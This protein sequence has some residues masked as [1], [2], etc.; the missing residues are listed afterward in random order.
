MLLARASLLL[1]FIS[2][3][4]LLSVAAVKHQDFKTCS[5]SGFCRRGRAIAE[6]A[7]ASNNWKSPYSVDSSSIDISNDQSSF[8]ATV[9]SSLYPDIK[10]RLDL[11]VLEDGV[12]RARMD[13]VDG[14]KQRYNEAASWVLVKEPTVSKS[15]QWTKGSKDIRA[16]YG[17]KNEV[18][19][20]V[21]Y[22]PL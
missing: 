5:Q 6:R 18:E 4:L 22:S 16:T 13:E 11:S 21:T 1:T 12:V 14:L 7:K 17:E 9:R 8:A 10:F 20:R 15:I 2:S 3:T 19:A